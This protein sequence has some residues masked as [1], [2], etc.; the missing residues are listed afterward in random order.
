MSSIKLAFKNVGKSIRDYAIYFL[1]LALGVC[2]FY[3]FNS[4]DSQALLAGLSMAQG[5]V[6]EMLVTAIDATSIFVSA[7]LAFLIVYANKFLMRRRKKELGVYLILGM[8]KGKVS[9]ILAME[10]LVIGL[11]ALAMGLIAGILLSQGLSV[12]VASMFQVKLEMFRFVFS[13]AALLKTL[14]YFGAIFLI[15]MLLNVVHVSRCKL[16]TLLNAERTNEKAYSGKLWLSV[17]AFIASA[18]CLGYAYQQ[19]IDNGLVLLNDQFNR[20]ILFGV[21]GTLLFF[22]SL[23][24]FLLKLIKSNKALYHRGLNSFVFR[25]LNSK[26]NT[27]FLSMTFVCLMLFFAIA[28]TATGSGLNYAITK[29]AMENAPYDATV[30]F[31]AVG[32]Q[33][34]QAQMQENSFEIDRYFK[35]SYLF[36]YRETGIKYTQYLEPA[37]FPSTGTNISSRT[38]DAISVSQYNALMRLQG[39]K[40]IA[41]GQGEYAVCAA[42][43]KTRGAGQKLL[44]TGAVM[45]VGQ[46]QLKPGKAELQ[47]VY[48]ETMTSNPVNLILILPDDAAAQI[49][50]YRTYLAGNYQ[51][52]DKDALDLQ[53][54]TDYEGVW[55]GMRIVTA[56]RVMMMQTGMKAMVLFV[57]LYLGIIFLIAASAV[58][59]LQQLSETADNASRYALLRKLG[60]DDDMARGA[61]RRQVAL[62]FF[63]P[64][65]LALV[66]SA[67]AIYVVNKMVMEFRVQNSLPSI[68]CSAGLLLVLYGIYYFATYQSCKGMIRERNIK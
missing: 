3:V 7:I 57:L 54:D 33:E 39:K 50:E 60:V 9:F 43:E 45:Q 64:L 17:I 30:S 56:G 16:V 18:G 8:P 53:L 67:V 48:L 15:V 5:G 68:L 1:T 26:I 41:L 55:P 4:M 40:E 37:D 12:L 66:H 21:I 58:L 23:S 49:P 52:G 42:A 28:V 2:I 34:A 11:F 61:M 22:F 44:D 36:S 24:G 51:S 35:E 65:A 25:Q 46:E 59:A 29:T 19:I 31:D 63:I 10:T 14:L 62:Y 13:T 27:N 6:L 20:A 38:F 32:E 47:T